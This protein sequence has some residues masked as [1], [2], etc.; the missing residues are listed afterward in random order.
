MIVLL[1]R[2]VG[3][4]SNPRVRNGISAKRVTTDHEYLRVVRIN[5]QRLSR[6]S[7]DPALGEKQMAERSV[8]V[9]RGLCGVALESLRCSHK[10]AGALWDRQ[11]FDARTANKAT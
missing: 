4:G 7:K 6:H 1:L 9:G 3:N 2:K 5:P 11:C 10:A 8:M